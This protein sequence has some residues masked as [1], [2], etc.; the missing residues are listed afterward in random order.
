MG[1][2]N[3]VF[4]D[5]ETPRSQRM[6]AN[7][8]STARAPRWVT[9]WNPVTRFLLAAR[10]P[11]GPNALLTVAGRTTGI[12]RTT[13]LAI[14]ERSGRRWVWSPWGEVQWVRNLR[15]AGRATITFR[16]REEQVRAR[17]LEAAERVAFFRDTLGPL[18]R[19]MRGGM[20]FIRLFDGVDLR[21]PMKA[22]EGRF[23][24]ELFPAE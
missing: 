7:A 10:A 16:R 9:L 12:P 13:P 11:L 8:T 15:A 21:D 4:E 17:E 19:S 6:T 3:G 23:V 18:A 2:V 22:A 14:I 5:L 20:W 1:G 24:F